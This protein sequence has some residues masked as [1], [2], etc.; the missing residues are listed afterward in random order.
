M[1]D[2][3]LV[4]LDRLEQEMQGKVMSTN[5]SAIHEQLRPLL[6]LVERMGEELRNLSW[7]LDPN[8]TCA[9][10]EYTGHPCAFDDYRRAK[11]DK[12]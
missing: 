10:T 12:S 6:D 3:N 11:G 4:E 5:A 7:H 1:T 9:D 8:D 2:L